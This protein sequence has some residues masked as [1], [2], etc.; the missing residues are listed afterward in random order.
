MRI[1]SW[2]VNGLRAILQ[3][4]FYESFEKMRPDIL[5]LQEIKVDKDSIPK[6]SLPKFEKIYNSAMRKGYAG[7]ALFTNK[8][9]ISIDC[10]TY[11]ETLTG[12]IEGRIILAE[13]E[14]FFL[15]NDYTPNSGN[16]L[17]RLNFRHKIWDVEVLKFVKELRKI[18][19][20]ILCGDM[21]VAHENIDLS[22]PNTN[23]F[24]AGFTDEEREGFRNFLSDFA[25]DSFR[26]FFPDKDNSYSWWSYRMRCRERNVG[27]RIDY[28]LVDKVIRE[29]IKSAFILSDVGGSDHAPVGI[30]IDF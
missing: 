12:E 13:Y 15:L 17:V 20:V 23:H 24:S 19:P 26:E 18:K 1:I 7:T 27:W 6:I 3:K 22:D 29:K 30:D 21:N 9:P 4:N 25:V 14:N 11:L 10:K 8:K 28:V 5:C 2:N 16:E